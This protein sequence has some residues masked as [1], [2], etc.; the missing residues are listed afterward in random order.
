MP[1]NTRNWRDIRFEE[2]RVG[3]NCT[4]AD[5]AEATAYL[6]IADHLTR[7]IQSSNVRSQQSRQTAEKMGEFKSAISRAN[8]TREMDLDLEW[9]FQTLDHMCKFPQK[10][11][12]R[13]FCLHLQAVIE[14]E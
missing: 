1:T 9:I 7:T 10:P 13:Q 4:P 14:G 3:I 12:V 2:L 11:L 6:Q 5:F 8:T